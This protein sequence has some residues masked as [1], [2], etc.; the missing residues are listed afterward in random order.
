MSCRSRSLGPGLSACAPAWNPA[1]DADLRVSSLLHLE[2]ERNGVDHAAHRRAILV[3]DHLA[4]MPKPESLDGPLL[5][6]REPDD[7]LDER[8][9]KRLWQWSPPARLRSPCCGA[10]A[11]TWAPCG[12]S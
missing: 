7:A 6:R 4:D 3:L 5:L 9:P 11:E 2:A 10:R 1:P 8:D 12:R